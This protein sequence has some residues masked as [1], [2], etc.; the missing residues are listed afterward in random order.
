[1]K[2]SLALTTHREAIRDIVQAHRACNARVFGSVLHGADTEASDL[3]ILIDPT[4]ETTLFDIGA[5]RHELLQL[6]GVPVDVLTP[7]ALPKKFRASV[8]AEAMP[9]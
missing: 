5:I 6:L 9:I 2:P 1:M 7:N 4:P 3:D 8:I